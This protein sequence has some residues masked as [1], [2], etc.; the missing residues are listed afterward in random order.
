MP[1]TK[2][3]FH[4]RLNDKNKLEKSI[5][6]KYFPGHTSLDFCQ[7]FMEIGD[8]TKSIARLNLSFELTKMTS[9][10]YQRESSCDSW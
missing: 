7:R 10:I 2:P 3:K 6:A 8:G 5:K 9:M 1:K 4:P